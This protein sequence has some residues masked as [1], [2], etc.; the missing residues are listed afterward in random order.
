MTFSGTPDASMASIMNAGSIDLS[1]MQQSLSIG[2]LNGSGAIALGGNDLTL[3]ALDH[4]DSFSGVISG[5]GGLNKTGTGNLTLSGANLYAGATTVQAGTLDLSGSLASPIMVTNQATLAGAGS[6]SSNLQ[7][8]SG[9]SFQ[10][11]G[12]FHVGGNLLLSPQ[13]QFVVGV[14]PTAAASS[15]T[16]SGSASINAANLSI[17]ASGVATSYAP[18]TTYTILSASQGVSGTFNQVAVNLPLLSPSVHYAPDDV[19]LT[20]TQLP[21]TGGGAGSGINS[22]TGGS[23][24]GTGTTGTGTTGTGTT[25]TGTTSTGSTSGSGNGSSSTLLTGLDNLNAT[26][27][28]N[29]ISSLGASSYGAMRRLELEDADE[30]PRKVADHLYSQRTLDGD[31]GPGWV[32]LEASRGSEDG[33]FSSTSWNQSGLIGGL[34]LRPSETTVVGLTAQYLR[35][36]A[37]PWQRQQRHHQPA[38]L[39]RRGRPDA[40]QFDPRRHAEL[41]PAPRRCSAL[42]RVR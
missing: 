7:V 4:S 12:V 16:A 36:S 2:S 31:Q 9:G 11:S 6:T 38:R 3:G 8:L 30:F 1:L 15:V 20:F 29:A 39:R 21:V 19:T 33:S 23:G 42:Y 41:R 18:A 26:S 22:M 35:G 10:P 34:D 32:E 40:R 27:L 17:Q 5:T 37:S 13:S 14:T 24:T 25:V 28:G